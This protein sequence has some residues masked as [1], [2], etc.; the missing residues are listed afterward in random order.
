MET[1]ALDDAARSYQAAVDLRPGLLAYDR[2]GWLRWME[3]DVVGAREM[4]E[5]AVAAGSAADPEP[6]AFA[7]TRLGWL[8][9]LA[10]EPAPQLDAALDLVPGYAPALL[11][12]ARVR[13]YDGWATPGVHEREGGLADLDT[14]H[15]NFEALRLLREFV[16]GPL[17]AAIDPRGYADAIARTDPAAARAR[18]E[19]E[20]RARQD[21]ITLSTHGWAL[22]H[23]GDARGAE[24]WTRKALATGCPEPRLV[25]HAA[26]VLG[27]VALARR[28]LA[29]GV[30]LLPSERAE[31]R[32][33]F[34]ELAE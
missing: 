16:P 4:A 32:A 20:L 6:L 29:M 34:P 9:A 26:I 1:G 28:A 24:E 21:A 25:H 17:D 5:L 7:L 31:L 2:I 13:L 14:L 19:V 23:A 22:H 12:R 10:G 8:R 33:R 30:G 15:G 11:A 3:G 27:D 18:I